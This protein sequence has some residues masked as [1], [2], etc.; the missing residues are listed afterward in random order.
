[1]TSAKLV[2]DNFHLDVGRQV[3][4]CISAPVALMLQLPILL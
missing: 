1:M 3:V 2:I 4:A